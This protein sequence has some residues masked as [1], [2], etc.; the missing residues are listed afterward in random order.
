MSQQ[1]ALDMIIQLLSC[2]VVLLTA[3]PVHELAHGFVAYKLGDP[4]AKN[5]GRLTDVYKRQF[6]LRSIKSART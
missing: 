2:L 1:M 4:T 5:A 3:I 6:L